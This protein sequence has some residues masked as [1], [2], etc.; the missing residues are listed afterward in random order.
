MAS[1]IVVGAVL[2]RD[3]D[4]FHGAVASEIAIAR[5]DLTIKIDT[6]GVLS[7]F[8]MT[9]ASTKEYSIMRRSLCSL[10]RREFHSLRC[11]RIRAPTTVNPSPS[12]LDPLDDEESPGEG[13]RED[14]G[15]SGECL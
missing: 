12:T 5:D 11:R 14:G 8:I 10:S 2:G 4:F 9:L 15:E 1:L 7:S 3:D 13:E 6:S